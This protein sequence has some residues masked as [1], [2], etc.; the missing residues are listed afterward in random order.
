MP[1][2][3]PALLKFVIIMC[4]GKKKIQYIQVCTCYKHWGIMQHNFS[5][6]LVCWDYVN[7]HSLTVDSLQPALFSSGGLGNIWCNEVIL[8]RFPVLHMENWNS[9]LSEWTVTLE[10]YKCRVQRKKKRSARLVFQV[11]DLKN[12][13]VM[14]MKRLATSEKTAQS[15]S[16]VQEMTEGHTTRWPRSSYPISPSQKTNEQTNK[17][18]ETK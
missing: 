5:Y 10:L 14:I 12:T 4:W 16:Y 7:M 1:L 6:A 9:F 17:R 18:T 13:M 11:N 15:H 2:L 3:K 8:H